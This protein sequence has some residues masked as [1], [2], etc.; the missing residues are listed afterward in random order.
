MSRLI[1]RI[2]TDTPLYTADD[3][4]GEGAKRSGGRWNRKGKPVIYCADSIA[5]AV[6]ETFVHLDS[7]LLPLNRYLVRIEVP[8]R[9]WK[10]ATVLQPS[11]MDVGW[12]AEPPGKISLDAGDEWLTSNG[13]LLLRV[14][15]VIVPIECNVLIN[16]QHPETTELKFEKIQ[17]WTYDARMVKVRK[18]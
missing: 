1:W 15:S 2:A 17:R 11:S 9:I 3:A 13:S 4:T 6:L 8:D 16:P 7:S 12:D 14:P 10:K 18:R 5:L